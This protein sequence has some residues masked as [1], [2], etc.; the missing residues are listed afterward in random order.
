MKLIT[1]IS[2]FILLFSCIKSFGQYSQAMFDSNYRATL[3]FGCTFQH[4]FDGSPTVEWNQSEEIS[5]GQWS[6]IGIFTDL[7]VKVN[8]MY[9]AQLTVG[10]MNNSYVGQCFQCGERGDIESRYLSHFSLKMRK[11]FLNDI[12]VKIDGIGGLQYRHGTESEIVSYGTFDTH[13][14][15]HDLRDLGL[16]LGVDVY[17]DIIKSRIRLSASITYTEYLY[18]NSRGQYSPYNWDDG[19][20]RRMMQFLFSI[21]YNFG[22]IPFK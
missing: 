2:L 14:L 1:K 6:N 10:F 18:R 4:F 22:Q 11:S 3:S 13:V 12:R 9:S 16:L 21:G 19:S 15:N 8:E 5:F 17:K 20:S 7:I